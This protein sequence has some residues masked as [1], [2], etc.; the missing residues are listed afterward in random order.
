MNTWLGGQEPLMTR[1]AAAAATPNVTRVFTEA[2]VL[3][4]QHPRGVLSA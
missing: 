2:A 3:G 4:V 1:R